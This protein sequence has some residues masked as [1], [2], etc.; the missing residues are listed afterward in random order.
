M[1]TGCGSLTPG[2]L[3]YG[4]NTS[5]QG[6][7]DDKGVVFPS[8]DCWTGIIAARIAGFSWAVSN[9]KNGRTWQTRKLKHAA[10]IGAESFAAN[11]PTFAGRC[12]LTG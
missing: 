12:D 9:E 6:A 3:A 2:E 5:I 11:Y 1:L 10:N 4:Y 8:H 7:L